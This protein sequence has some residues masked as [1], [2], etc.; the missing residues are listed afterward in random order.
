M[1]TWNIYF[2]LKERINNLQKQLTN[3]RNRLA[4]LKGGE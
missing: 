4:I 1:E 3:Y 2:E